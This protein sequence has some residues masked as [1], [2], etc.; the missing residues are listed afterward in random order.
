MASLKRSRRFPRDSSILQPAQV[1]AARRALFVRPFLERL[2][3]RT[4]LSLFAP[5]AGSPFSTSGSAPSDA[6]AAD[7][8]GDGKMDLA[9]TNSTS[10]TVTVF[11]RS[12]NSFTQSASFS[13]GGSMPLGIVAAD[14]NGDGKMDLAVTNNGSGTV[15]VF[16]GNGDGTFGSAAIYNVGVAPVGIAAADI[17]HDG[18]IDLAVAN[19]GSH[20]MSVLLN[21]GNGTFGTA[22]G[23]NVGTSP[24]G[25]AA[26]P[27]NVTGKVLLAVANSGSNT[28]STFFGYSAGSFFTS[29]SFGTGPSP[30]A[31]VAADFNGDGVPDLAVTN[32]GGHTISVFAGDAP[33]VTFS[34]IGL[35]FNSSVSNAAV[36]SLAVGDF[37]LDGRS[38]LVLANSGSSNL[39]AFYGNGDGT[40]SVASGSPFS[41]S[42]TSPGGV[43]SADFNGDGLLDVALVDN[44]SNVFEVMQNALARAATTVGSSDSTSVYGEPVTFT[45]AVTSASGTPTGTVSFTDSVSEALGVSTLTSGVATT[46]F[47]Y[48]TLGAHVVTATYSGDANFIGG[49]A[50]ISQTV[51]AA[52][53]T[54]VLTSSGSP[55]NYAQAVTFTA[56]VTARTPSTAVVAGAVTFTDSVSGV[57]GTQPLNGSGVAAL[58]SSA[59][60]GGSHTITATFNANTDFNGSSN[61]VAQSVTPAATTTTITTSGSPSTFGQAVSFIASVASAV[62][63]PTGLVAFSDSVSGL[64]GTVVLAGGVAALTTNTLTGAG[65]TITA[66]YTPNSPN[67]AG[68]AGTVG[69]TVGAASTTITVATSASPLVVGQVAAFTATV[70]APGGAVSPTGIV[71]F[72]DGAALLGTGGL[73]GGYATFSTSALSVGSHSITAV[74]NANPNFNG[75]TSSPITEQMNPGP[76]THFLVVAANGTA[77]AGTSFNV[78]V[79]AQDSFNDTATGYTGTVHF[80]SSD[81]QALLPADGTLTNGVGMF[82]VTL[83]TAGSQTLTLADGTT[84]SITGVSG[85]VAVS[86]AA[87]SHFAVAAPAGITAGT[88]F[89][90][91]VAALDPYG[92][93]ATS[94]GGAVHFISNDPGASL[95]TNAGLSNGVGTF[96]ATFFNAGSRTLTATDAVV[97]SITG[98]SPVAVV[99]T[100]DPTFAVVAPANAVTGVSFTF[101]VVAHDQF[102]NTATL[103]NGAVHFTSSDSLALLPADAT[104]TNGAGT[105]TATMRTAGS[106]TITATDT[107]HLD[108]VGRSNPIAAQG[109]VVSSFTRTPTGFTATFDKPFNPAVINLYDA[110]SA[111]YGPADVVVA[112]QLAA[113]NPVKGSLLIDPTSTTITFVKTGGVLTPDTYTVTLVSGANAF[114]DATGVALDGNNSGAPGTNYTTTFTVTSSTAVVVSIPS[115][116]RG[117]DSTHNVNAPNTTTGGI[118]LKLSNGGGV[119]DVTLTV[120]YDPTLLNVSGAAVNSALSGATLTL[121]GT[122]T[123]GHAVLI[124]H[125]PTALASGAA[126]LGGLVAQVP[127]G[128]PYRNK[129]LLDLG[130]IQINGGAI[131]AVADD[132]VQVVAYFADSS[133]NGAFSGLDGSLISRVAS[134][135]DSGFAAFRLLDPVIL[136]DVNGNG[137]IDS[138][139]ASQFAQFL[140]NN[141]SVPAIPPIPSPGPSLAFGGPDPTLSLPA[142][143][144]ADAAGVVEVPVLLD[145]P[146][147]DG[148]T[149]MTEASLALTY[150]PAALTVTAAD[151][152]L[153]SIPLSGIG[154]RLTT[155]VD[156]TT[157]RIGVDLFSPTPVADAA[158]GSLVVIDFHLAASGMGN[159]VVQLV[160][161]VAVDGREF[162]TEVDDDQGA[163]TLTPAPTNAA[164]LSAVVS[165]L[166]TATQSTPATASPPVRVEGPIEL[167]ATLL[168]DA[169]FVNLGREAATASGSG[170]SATAATAATHRPPPTSTTS[171]SESRYPPPASRPIR[172][173][174]LF[175]APPPN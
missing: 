144:T 117:P 108:E 7:F 52:G 37:N 89:Y 14:F 174:P 85:L 129:A 56:T 30:T 116:A 72:F 25:I 78:T 8:N 90:F 96:I 71:S 75:S 76:W 123:P 132:G 160:G 126:T 12:G 154:W 20:S 122:S 65:H 163:F 19:S 81:G 59:L 102:N 125:S 107:L 145:H 42:G 171:R 80:T 21:N 43:T 167:E 121:S 5:A 27:F 29:N 143:L 124:F 135:L 112:G 120:N 4:V 104:L 10:G 57:L 164:P 173:Q 165:S 35:P 157:G 141:A 133:G 53:T 64:L 63:T 103:Y 67:F 131:S 93:T 61:M 148:S 69:Q 146:H 114:K 62:G 159:A 91:T 139:D 54:T 60:S 48:T 33:T 1:P 150:D 175:W 109:F 11:L 68:S 161:S 13:S 149:G 138:N 137:R 39:A 99:P 130:S 40:F 88:A 31:I 153:G 147:P 118:P 100:A 95:P 162:R 172:E 84:S 83:K 158:G 66:S 73:S 169:V 36:F 3:D 119:T 38:D 24:Q 113:N 44:G 46:T 6:A 166:A 2:E 168:P 18:K 16:P 23:F 97:S 156:P 70:A 115:F 15:A 50:T 77:T 9:V 55:S 94:Y 86:A 127:D 41:L 26:I 152:H 34:Q 110:A 79:T 92:N 74:F 17:D 87:A 106:Q 98:S 136:A 45:A 101:T 28:V 142:T 140:S 47:T 82:S 170:W 151:V 134:K 51:N 111:N 155:V 58:T 49:F 22:Q 128:A 105:F 32:S